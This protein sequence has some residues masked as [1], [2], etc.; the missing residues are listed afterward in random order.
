MTMTAQSMT[1]DRE[2][3]FEFTDRDFAF[4]REIVTGHSG[5]TLGEQKRQLVY[6]RLAR[7]LRQLR[8]NS[9]AEYCDYVDTHLEQELGELINAIT[10]NLTSFFRE[11]HHFEHLA[12]QALPEIMAHNATHRRLRIWSAGCSTGEEPYSIAMTVLES[13][14][15][16][17]GSWDARILATDIDTQVVARAQ[18][19][20]YPEDRIEGLAPS[21]ARRWFS[22]GTGPNAGKVR[23]SP[24]L[25]SIIAFK[26][27]NLLKDWPMRGPFD[28][29]FCRNVVIYFD[30][31]TQRT[32]F[33]RYANLLAPHGYLYVGHSESL[34]QISNRFKL[35]GKTIYQR[36]R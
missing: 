16:A 31:D 19:G 35:I 18:A 30:K 25:Q 34:H 20:V 32:L 26:Q 17:L 6:G 21:R 33:D 10:T 12:G 7:R 2:R 29:I 23:V 36:T 8:L 14:G 27:L 4:L 24:E 13:G 1:E 11:N 28:I 3:E 5:I 15:S 9:F 22:R